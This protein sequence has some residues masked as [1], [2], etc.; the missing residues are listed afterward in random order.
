MLLMWWLSGRQEALFHKVQVLG[1]RVGEV[2]EGVV[3][4]LVAEIFVVV[5]HGCPNYAHNNNN[6]K[7][8]N[9]EECKQKCGKITT[10]ANLV[11]G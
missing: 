3:V 1:A 6:N 5:V 7:N 4:V 2:R 10:V 9:V 8:D 11:Y